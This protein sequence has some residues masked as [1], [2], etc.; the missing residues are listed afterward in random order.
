MH[1]KTKQMEREKAAPVLLAH[2]S[3]S[4]LARLPTRS[5]MG[6]KKAGPPSQKGYGSRGAFCAPG[7]P[8]SIADILPCAELMEHHAQEVPRWV[9][10][11]RPQPVWEI[12]QLWQPH[13]GW[14]ALSPLPTYQAE[15]N[16][17]PVGCE[18]S[19]EASSSSRSCG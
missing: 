13:K 2:C 1:L 18:K 4:A 6:W 3:L 7:A 14:A 17:A 8:G 5:L 16:S 19:G 12:R 11:Q 15:S 9:L 10:G